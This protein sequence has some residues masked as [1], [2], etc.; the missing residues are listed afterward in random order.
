MCV[1]PYPSLSF[2]VPRCL[3]AKLLKNAKYFFLF[4][5][6]NMFILL[7]FEFSVLG[8]TYWFLKW[9]LKGFFSSLFHPPHNTYVNIP[10]L[11]IKKK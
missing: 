10:S 4:I 7:F 6:L 9:T 1:P 11:Y 5:F 8:I 2:P 3:E